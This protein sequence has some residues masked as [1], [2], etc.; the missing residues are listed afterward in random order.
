MGATLRCLA[1]SLF[2]LALSTAAIADHHD[3]LMQEVQAI[4]DALATAMVENDVDTMFAMYADDAISLPNFGPRMDG[5]ET[6]RKHHEE[7]AASGMKISSFTSHPTDVWKAGD[8]VI[9]IGTF[10]IELE[11]PGM[12]EKIQDKGKYLTVYVRDA[13]GSLKVKVETW[14]TD[15]NPMEMGE[16]G[17]EHGHEHAP[18]G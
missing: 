6:F 5:I 18:E 17:H 4:G 3:A 1:V 10:E 9:E 7:M 13:D 16:H 8:Q 11:M 2:I 12:P 15:T 14:N